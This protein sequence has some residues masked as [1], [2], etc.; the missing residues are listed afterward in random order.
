MGN[1]RW[2]KAQATAPILDSTEAGMH[3]S[4]SI[5]SLART[6]ID[7]GMMMANP[8]RCEDALPGQAVG[9]A[10]REQNAYFSRLQST[11][12]DFVVGRDR[13]DLTTNQITRRSW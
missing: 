13:R 1:G 8:N 3:P 11:F 4:H 12:A 2:P 5:T 7:V 10:A 9:W 6:R